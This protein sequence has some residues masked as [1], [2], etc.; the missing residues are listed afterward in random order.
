MKIKVEIEAKQ[1]FQD[2]EEIQNNSCEGEI[3]YLQKGEILEFIEKQQEH[4]M[5]FKMTVLPNKVISVREGQQMIFD[6]EKED[7]VKY[8]T[9][10][11]I[12]YMKIH[13]QEIIQKR[14]ENRL[15][16]VILRYTMTLENGECYDNE[17]TFLITQE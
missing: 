9:P 13:T 17:V 14:K 10:Y 15:Q 7:H 16:Q 6:L 4:E 11:G 1:K 3:T 5:H 12:L 8:E 2:H